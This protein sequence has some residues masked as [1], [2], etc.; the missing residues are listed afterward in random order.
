MYRYIHMYIYIYIHIHIYI[1]IYTI[2]IYILY[3][4]IYTYMYVIATRPYR[5]PPVPGDESCSLELRD[6]RKALAFG[7]LF[8]CLFCFARKGAEGASSNGVTANVLR[9]RDFLGTPVNLLVS[10]RK[11]QGIPFSPI[12]QN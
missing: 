9:Q 12:C 3:I 4:Y 5:G 2:Y 8:C 10:S 6:A 7:R 1:Y 11:C